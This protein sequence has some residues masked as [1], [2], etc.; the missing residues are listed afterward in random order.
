MVDL[1]S[2]IPKVGKDVITPVGHRSLPLCS[3]HLLVQPRIERGC[4]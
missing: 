3:I 1:S 2:S 4:R